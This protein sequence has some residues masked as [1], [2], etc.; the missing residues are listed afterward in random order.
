[1]S[2]IQQEGELSV[3]EKVAAVPAFLAKVSR[4]RPRI[5]CFVGMG[6]WVDAV[7]KALR[8]IAVPPEAVVPPTASSPSHV[9][10]RRSPNRKSPKLKKTMVGL[11]P[12]KMV[13][14]KVDGDGKV[15][16]NTI[17]PDY[18]YFGHL[19]VSVTETFFFV[20]PSTSGR[21]TQYQVCVLLSQSFVF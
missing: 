20:V 7:E 14:P 1:M 9:P 13:Q 16:L 12:Y 11:Q 21:V 15:P 19:D 8:Q 2:S 17:L 4:Y 10:R 3:A 5:V 6:I 18:K